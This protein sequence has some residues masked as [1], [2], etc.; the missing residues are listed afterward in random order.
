MQVM[1]LRTLNSVWSAQRNVEMPW[2][3]QDRN[4]AVNMQLERVGSRSL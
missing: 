3:Y 2:A 4:T 1:I